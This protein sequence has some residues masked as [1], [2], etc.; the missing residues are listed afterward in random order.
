MSMD[1]GVHVVHD[2]HGEPARRPRT[3]FYVQDVQGH[4]ALRAVGTVVPRVVLLDAS[5][6]AWSRDRTRTDGAGTPAGGSPF[7]KNTPVSHSGFEHPSG[8]TS[9]GSM[10]P[11]GLLGQLEDHVARRSWA[12]A[13]SASKRPEVNAG[14]RA[15]PRHHVGVLQRRSAERSPSCPSFTPA[16]TATDSTTWMPASRHRSMAR[17]LHVQDVAPARALVHLAR[18]ARRTTGTRR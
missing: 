10:R 2:D 3:P 14:C 7:T 12:A 17:E 18:S 1:T 15:K 4:R 5:W 13:R 16:T 6:R 9:R 8:H 11:V